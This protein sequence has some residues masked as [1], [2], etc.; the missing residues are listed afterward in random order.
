MDPLHTFARFIA[1]FVAA[2]TAVV[3][4]SLPEPA[5]ALP[6]D[7]ERPLAA[8]TCA[9]A[10]ARLEEARLGSPLVSEESN[11]RIQ[12]MAEAYVVSLCNLD[13]LGPDP[14]ATRD[15]DG[16]AARSVPGPVPSGRSRVAQ[17]ANST[18]VIEMP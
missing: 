8:Q 5:M 4:L 14:D 16:D 11:L 2:V 9:E 18:P 17:N 15:P 10:Q 1:G 13:P 12:Q 3:V 7:P 6:P